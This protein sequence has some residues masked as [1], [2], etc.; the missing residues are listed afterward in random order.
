MYMQMLQLFA[1]RYLYTVSR[2][3]VLNPNIQSTVFRALWG[4]H[5][6]LDLPPAKVIWLVCL[7]EN[8]VVCGTS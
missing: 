6:R 2:L 1:E 5:M 7:E 4:T 3:V 8:P